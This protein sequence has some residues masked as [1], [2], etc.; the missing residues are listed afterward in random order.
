M[1]L[2]RR[3]EG[4]KFSHIKQI[5]IKSAFVLVSPSVAAG[6][7]YIGTIVISLI[8]SLSISPV[9]MARYL[10]VVIGPFAIMISTIFV[11]ARRSFVV[12]VGIA[13]LSVLALS[14]ITEK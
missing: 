4:Q 3:G 8:I 5:L 14:H 6:F 7:V 1:P 2:F 11:R 10:F 9:L 13:S 12:S